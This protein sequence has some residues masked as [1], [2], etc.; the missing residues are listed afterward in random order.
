M[1]FIYYNLSVKT[2]IVL[3]GIGG[4]FYDLSFIEIAFKS[5]KNDFALKCFKKND[6]H[7]ITILIFQ[8]IEFFSEFVFFFLLQIIFYTISDKYWIISVALIHGLLA[9]FTP[10]YKF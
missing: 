5:V 2:I 1:C 6:R 10:S 8:V 4:I 9:F 7:N 3:F